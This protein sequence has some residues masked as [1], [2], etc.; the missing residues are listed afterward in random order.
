VR[1]TLPSTAHRERPRPCICRVGPP[2][3]T[4]RLPGLGSPRL[5]ARR[6]IIRRKSPAPL[7]RST[8]NGALR[9]RARSEAEN[10]PEGVVS[11]QP[12]RLRH[13]RYE[14][15]DSGTS[16]RFDTIVAQISA[17]SPMSDGTDSASGI[18]F[19]FPNPTREARIHTHKFHRMLPE[20]RWT[21]IAGSMEIGM[22]IV[23]GSP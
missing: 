17:T 15:S 21:Q 6:H 10:M 12:R 4:G 1:H 7:A 23:H 20:G 19:R 5:V 2:T 11:W 9:E 22:N 3:C 16:H 13:E 18:R 8:P 14:R